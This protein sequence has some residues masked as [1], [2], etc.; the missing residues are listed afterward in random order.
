[1][2]ILLLGASLFTE[3]S[4][5]RRSVEHVALGRRE[6]GWRAWWQT[7]DPF[8][9]CA[10]GSSVSRAPRVILL[11][12]IGRLAASVMTTSASL[13]DSVWLSRIWYT[14]NAQAHLLLPIAYCRIRMSKRAL[15]RLNI[16]TERRRCQVSDLYSTNALRSDH[17]KE[18][19]KNGWFSASF[20]F[21]FLRFIRLFRLGSRE[22]CD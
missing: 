6:G 4:V 15:S 2:S 10:Q 12:A 14:Y 8:S 9:Y 16:T 1:M 22:I 7:P 13:Q 3:A 19:N 21:F 17:K 11:P 20:S 18:K 5:Q